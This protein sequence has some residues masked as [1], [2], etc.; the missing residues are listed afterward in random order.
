MKTVMA[1]YEENASESMFWQ[2]TGLPQSVADRASDSLADG[3]QNK[4]QIVQTSHQPVTS[5][6]KFR[7][8]TIEELR[9]KRLK[10]NNARKNNMPQTTKK[11]KTCP[12]QV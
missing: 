12:G 8:N 9:R 5:Q 3:R 10:R 1:E 4:V 7:R 2:A 11:E 6:R